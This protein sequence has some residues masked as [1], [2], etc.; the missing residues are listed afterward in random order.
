M[1]EHTDLVFH[2]QTASI[3]LGVFVCLWGLTQFGRCLWEILLGRQVHHHMCPYHA[4]TALLCICSLI[5]AAARANTIG[6][7]DLGPHF[8]GWMFSGGMVGFAVLMGFA[9]WAKDHNHFEFR[10]A[11][12]GT[13][14]L[15]R[16]LAM[17][18]II[19]VAFVLV[20]LVK[21]MS[22]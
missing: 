18:F 4:G 5:F 20:G 19:I 2:M 22:E 21:G 15:G 1:Q 12:E 6:L 14:K 8:S 3:A 16:I 7:F 13:P 9:I 17:V 10:D 11:R